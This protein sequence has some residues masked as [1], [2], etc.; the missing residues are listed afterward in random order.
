MAKLHAVGAAQRSALRGEKVSTP[1]GSQR[2]TIHSKRVLPFTVNG[3]NAFDHG[4]KRKIVAEYS[5]K[6]FDVEGLKLKQGR[7]KHPQGS[8]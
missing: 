5:G 2:G 1:L 7:S 6:A 3:K 4:D 8:R